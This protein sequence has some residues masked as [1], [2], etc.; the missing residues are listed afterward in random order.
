MSKKHSTL[1]RG[2]RGQ[3]FAD[4]ILGVPPEQTIMVWPNKTHALGDLTVR[5]TFAIPFSGN[6]LS[7]GDRSC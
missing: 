1:L 5:T 4:L 2:K 7:L 3:A 6:D